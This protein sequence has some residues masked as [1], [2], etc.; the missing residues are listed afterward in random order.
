MTDDDK[1]TEPADGD[2]VDAETTDLATTPDLSQ[3]PALSDNLRPV[4]MKDGMQL[5]PVEEQAIVLAEYTKRRQHFREWLLSQMIQGVHFGFPPGC[6]PGNTDEKQWQAKPSL[7]KAGA[8]L[9][10]DLLK[11]KVSYQSDK[12]GWEQAGSLAGTFVML[13]TLVD[14]AT[15]DIMGEGRGIYAVGEKK[16]MGANSAIKMAEKRAMVDAVMH[17][18]PMVA[19]L[20]TQDLETPPPSPA[21]TADPNAPAADTRDQRR[22]GPVTTAD[23]R[24]AYET[25]LEMAKVTWPDEEERGVLFKAYVNSV[26]QATIGG[27]SDWS[28]S[29]LDTVIAD[30]AERK[31]PAPK[32]TEGE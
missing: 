9:I 13:A 31:D 30:L 8:L 10:I 28:W 15:G 2:I 14:A 26:C 5:L 4:A 7:Y 25:W 3:P 19:D 20:F 23:I 6:R 21:P 11:L 18:V 32:Q 12:I 24:P 22:Q 27:I 17:S 16:G 29:R 1:P